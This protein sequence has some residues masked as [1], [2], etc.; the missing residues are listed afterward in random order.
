M[1]LTLSLLILLTACASKNK[2]DTVSIQSATNFN[3]NSGEE[4]RGL[5]T[6]R[7]SYLRHLFKYPGRKS[8]CMSPSAIGDIHTDNEGN[9]YSISR[10][11]LSGSGNVDCPGPK[12][13]QGNLIFLFCKNHHVLK[14]IGVRQPWND[15]EWE[16]KCTGN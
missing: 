12:M 16:L 13:R 6:S 14:E 3:V 10:I 11:Y 5:I 2:L 15:H 4:A 1:H 7:L 8:G 9:L